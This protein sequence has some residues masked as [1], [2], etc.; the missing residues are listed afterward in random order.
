MCEPMQPKA[1][2]GPEGFEPLW[3]IT[4]KTGISQH[5]GAESGAVSAKNDPTNADL[6]DWLDA[7]PMELTDEA[8][9]GIFAM[10]RVA[11]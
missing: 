9:A 4:G 7:C 2:V 10:I 1:R 5:G 8:K 6:A 3:E 11:E